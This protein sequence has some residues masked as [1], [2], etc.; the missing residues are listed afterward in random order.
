M[1]DDQL[2]FSALRIRCVVQLELI[3]TIDNVLFFPTTSRKDDEYN[4]ASS[5]GEECCRVCLPEQAM[6]PRLNAKQLMSL[7]QCLIDSH[8]FAKQFNSNNEQRIL[9][10][11]AEFRG[12]SKPNL[13]KQETTSLACALRVLFRMYSDS[14]ASQD[15]ETALLQLCSESLSYFCTLTSEGHRDTWTSV[16]LLLF[17]QLLDLSDEKFAKHIGVY[18]PHFCQLVSL[19]LKTELRSLLKR[20]LVRVGVQFSVVAAN[21]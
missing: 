20:V 2:L 1:T 7:L 10:W 3:Q 17:V 4:L 21:A 19:D 14:H 16:I 6:Y 11:K 5:R 15:V 9:L 13:L 18:Y 8:R 12:K